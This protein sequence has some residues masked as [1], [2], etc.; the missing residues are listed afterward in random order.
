MLERATNG[1]ATGK[2]AAAPWR[3]FE[4]DPSSRIK[5]RLQFTKPFKA[6]N[7]T[8][9]TFTPVPGGTEVSWIMNGENKGLTKVFALFMNMDKMVGSDFE[10]GLESLAAA[11][12]A[13]RN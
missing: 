8:T 7:P 4:S 11:V 3:L 6:L 10:R 5:I 13:S 2:P 1:A 9:F 12:S